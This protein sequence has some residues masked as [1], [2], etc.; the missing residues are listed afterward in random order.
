MHQES[1]SYY[2]VK[3]EPQGIPYSKDNPLWTENYFEGPPPEGYLSW[4]N[5]V[6]DSTNRGLFKGVRIT[7]YSTAGGKVFAS[8]PGVEADAETESVT[9]PKIDFCVN[10]GTALGT[11]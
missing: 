4:H 9:Q 5:W 8:Q 10:C 1:V 7:S 2:K 3:D 6:E 11:D